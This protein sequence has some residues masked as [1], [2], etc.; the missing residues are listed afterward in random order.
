MAQHNVPNRS[1][2]SQ[3]QTQTAIVCLLMIRVSP[4]DMSASFFFSYS[5]LS[6]FFIFPCVY[7]ARL[8]HFHSY[9]FILSVFFSP[10]PPSLSR[11]VI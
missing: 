6:S 11:V 5:L 2:M 7:V 3:T 4:D 8:P 1:S 9:M 10:F